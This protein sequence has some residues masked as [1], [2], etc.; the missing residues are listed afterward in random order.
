MILLA[1]VVWRLR[2]RI[3]HARARR[4]PAG[5]RLH[6]GCGPQ[7][8]EGWINIDNRRYPAVDFVL[9]V[10][11]G[12]PF[13]ALSGIFAEH[14]LEHLPYWEAARFLADCRRALAPDGVLRLS[15]PNL[16]WICATQ[17]H[18]P[19]WDSEAQPVSDCFR[20]NQAFQGWG[21]RFL[22]NLPVLRAVLREAGFRRIVLC[23]YGESE[24]AAL[25]GLERHEKAPD[26]PGLP[27]VIIVEASGIEPP[28]AD[29][30]LRE[31]SADFLQALGA[32]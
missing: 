22:Y 14:F 10:R 9:D 15:T 8:I 24:H 7:R 30:T 5:G 25:R 17:Y 26:G 3:N 32:S 1:R 2:T 16:D 12:I 29:A 19:A 31:A 4:L 6:V 20:I 23:D 28:V 13:R 27:H 21:H 18:Y 11:D